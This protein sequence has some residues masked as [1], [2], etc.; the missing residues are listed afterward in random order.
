MDATSLMNLSLVWCSLTA[1][2]ARRTSTTNSPRERKPKPWTSAKGGEER[3]R[4]RHLSHPYECRVGSWRQGLVQ[5]LCVQHTPTLRPLLVYCQSMC[6][7][8]TVATLG[9]RKS[10]MFWLA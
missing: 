7:V 8:L 2:S 10:T 1:T 4:L 3:H 9:M 6:M 5:S